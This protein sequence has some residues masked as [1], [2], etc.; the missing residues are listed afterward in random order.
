MLHVHWLAGSTIHDR[1]GND[2]RRSIA[3]LGVMLAASLPLLSGCTTADK[4][5]SEASSVSVSDRDIVDD[6]I[7]RLRQDP[8]TSRYP[9]SI[10]SDAGVVTVGGSIGYEDAR[11]RALSIVR[12][13]PG[14]VGV[15]DNLTR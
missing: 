9:F 10:T 14:V 2:V 7:D 4:T 15:I 5:G 11:V 3:M 8:V 1:E 12:G 6:V 13:A